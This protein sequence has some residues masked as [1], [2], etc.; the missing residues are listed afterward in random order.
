M[1]PIRRTIFPYRYHFSTINTHLLSSTALIGNH[2]TDSRI[3]YESLRNGNVFIGYDL[4]AS[5]YGFRFS[6]QSREKEVSMG[7]EI[8]LN[9]SITFQ[10]HIP[11]KAEISLLKDGK[12]IKK[13]RMENLVFVAKE[14]G[15]YRVEV[16]RNYLGKKRGWIYSNPIYVLPVNK[17]TLRK[18]DTV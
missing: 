6:A 3:I 16:H 13:T 12:I 18:S 10:V 4:P 9:G 11:K 7:D 14:P 15:V 17:S 2:I 8:E 5:T 1:G